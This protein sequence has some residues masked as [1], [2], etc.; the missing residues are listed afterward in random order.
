MGKSV[1]PDFNSR[2]IHVSYQLSGYEK[3]LKNRIK[4]FLIILFFRIFLSKLCKGF[5]L[6]RSEA[7]PLQK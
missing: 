5:S 7:S 4:P 1:F 2:M 6:L 3:A